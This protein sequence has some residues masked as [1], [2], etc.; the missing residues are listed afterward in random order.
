MLSSLQYTFWV[1]WLVWTIFEYHIQ[2]VSISADLEDL[3]WLTP[4]IPTRRTPFLLAG[5]LFGPTLSCKYW[6]L[7]DV[8]FIYRDSSSWSALYSSA[9]NGIIPNIKLIM[10][11]V[12]NQYGQIIFKSQLNNLAEWKRWRT[13]FVINKLVIWYMHYDWMLNSMRQTE[14]SRLQVYNLSKSLIYK[15]NDKHKCTVL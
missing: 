2:F 1:R 14:F 10:H 15:T 7:F 3:K 12:P 6:A 13:K 11:M 8:D 5:S 9:S 4:E